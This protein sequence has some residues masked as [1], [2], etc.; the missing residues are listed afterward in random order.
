MEVVG[1]NKR[2]WRLR[3][4]AD[5]E[6]IKD[7][8]TN[9][10][11]NVLGCAYL[12]DAFGEPFE[13]WVQHALEDCHRGKRQCF[14]LFDVTD[15]SFDIDIYP[16]AICFTKALLAGD[17]LLVKSVICSFINQEKDGL[18]ENRISEES[19]RRINGLLLG[20]ENYCSRV[21]L[22]FIEL[23][24]P[25]TA[26]AIVAAILRRGYLVGS[27]SRKRAN[28]G[29]DLLV[30]E[31]EV[32][33]VYA[34]D[35]FDSVHKALWLANSVMQW[36]IQGMRQPQKNT[37]ISDFIEVRFAVPG[38]V[39]V[40]DRLPSA[41]RIQSQEF[42]ER[43]RVKGSL[44]IPNSSTSIPLANS[45]ESIC[46]ELK[47]AH[48]RQYYF[49]VPSD[50][51]N[52]EASGSWFR[53]RSRDSVPANTILEK[54]VD[55]F[56]GT[57]YNP[58]GVERKQEIGGILLNVSPF[59]WP[60]YE[61]I[62]PDDDVGY[63]EFGGIGISCDLG[64]PEDLETEYTDSTL[65]LFYSEFC[66]PC[67]KI[68]STDRYFHQ[69][70]LQQERIKGYIWAI[71]RIIDHERLQILPDFQAESSESEDDLKKFPRNANLE[72]I[73]DAEVRTMM[74]RSEFRA[75]I[76]S[77]RFVHGATLTLTSFRVIEQGG[78]PLVSTDTAT[79]SPPSY[80]DQL[81][82]GD[83]QELDIAVSD[84]PFIHVSSSVGM[85]R[86]C[87]VPKSLARSILEAAQN[88]EVVLKNANDCSWTY[89]VVERRSSTEYGI[90][91]PH[92][93][94]TRQ[95]RS[96]PHDEI[97]NVQNRTDIVFKRIVSIICISSMVL[98]LLVLLGLSIAG[99][100]SSKVTL[101]LLSAL[102][103]ILIGIPMSFL[104]AKGAKA[105]VSG[106][107]GWERILRVDFSA[108]QGIASGCIIFLLT[109]LMS[110]ML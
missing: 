35:P 75:R 78:M 50:D 19:Q 55:K 60:F 53:N 80:P 99:I 106:E 76:S 77:R 102:S 54:E 74:S 95:M 34:G 48:G 101:I 2:V 8:I 23:S 30:F 92:A 107:F 88:G 15:R 89:E 81:D 87:Y 51:E 104:D 83:Q 40:S 9:R 37:P 28:T 17:T 24:L 105:S 52:R 41:S 26:S 93:P 5:L 96:T 68:V 71:G 25:Q 18:D 67:S 103:G 65:A 29:T 44:L 10:E 42:L 56:L 12:Y 33:P 16:L 110:L 63:V 98:I 13:E 49:F 108:I 7:R 72:E 20:I 58:F 66:P 22:R 94:P 59:E 86:S 38:L 1:D 31:K 97:P 46:N 85:I 100:E 79:P 6:V 21:G 70:N 64:E 90:V 39:G 27:T 62:S 57:G 11:V 43:F 84:M 73:F 69:F 91:Q 47:L 14:G 45:Y 36:S 32:T 109:L 4:E 61:A 3:G 82:L